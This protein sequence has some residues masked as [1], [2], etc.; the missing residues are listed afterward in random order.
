MSRI[1]SLIAAVLI[2]CAC[3]RSQE[4]NAYE[5]FRSGINEDYS[6]APAAYSTL[7]AREKIAVYLGANEI[8]PPDTRIA[9]LAFDESNEF[10]FALRDEVKNRNNYVVTFDYVNEVGRLSRA[11][12]ISSSEV[13][14]LELGD[15]CRSLTSQ[16]DACLEMLN[17]P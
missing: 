11:G 8:H 14:K 13:A 10:I 5:A 9:D 7:S 3:S 4:F 15:L 16:T 12:K 17:A 2:L 1:I 6:R